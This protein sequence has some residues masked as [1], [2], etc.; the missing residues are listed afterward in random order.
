MPI[1]PTNGAMKT[2]LAISLLMLTSC[3]QSET[4]LIPSGYEGPV[5]V[6]S[7]VE[8]GM[9]EILES[10]TRVFRIESNGVLKT[11]SKKVGIGM[12]FYYESNDGTRTPLRYVYSVD[13]DNYNPEDVLVFRKLMY[14]TGNI[15]FFVG[16]LN[17]LEEY[18]SA[19]EEM[20]QNL[21]TSQAPIATP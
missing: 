8:G 18:Y 2:C 6:I 16:R 10:G 4:Y 21:S 1:Q 14:S 12:E 7:G 3:Y 11:T 5:F 20:K 17:Q 19:L 9:P 15:S 13:E